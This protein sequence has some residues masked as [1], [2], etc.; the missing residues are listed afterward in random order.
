MTEDARSSS[1]KMKA[2]TIGIVAGA[3]FGLLSAFLYSRAAEEEAKQGD[4]PPPVPTTAMI[5]MLLSA[6]GLVRQITES[7]KPKK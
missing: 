7:G 1:W 6:L 5:G 4:G 3:L 2:Y